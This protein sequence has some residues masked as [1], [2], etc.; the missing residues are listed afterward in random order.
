MRKLFI[1]LSLTIGLTLVSSANA[2][3]KVV[4]AKGAM[5]KTH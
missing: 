5:S 2:Q 1:L 3:T 4:F